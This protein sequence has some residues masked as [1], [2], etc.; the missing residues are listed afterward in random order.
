MACRCRIYDLLS[1]DVAVLPV[2][3]Q[4]GNSLHFRGNVTCC[5]NLGTGNSWFWCLTGG[6]D[7]PTDLPGCPAP[8]P[9][10]PARWRQC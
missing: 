10:R 3:S 1:I 5:L 4:G 7:P 8:R 9:S 6:Y 2:A